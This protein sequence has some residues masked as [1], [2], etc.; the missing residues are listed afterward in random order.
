MKKEGALSSQAPVITGGPRDA[1]EFGEERFDLLPRRFRERWMLQNHLL[2]KCRLVQVH[3][4]P[5]QHVTRVNL[6]ISRNNPGLN[7]GQTSNPGPDFAIQRGWRPGDGAALENCF[8]HEHR[9]KL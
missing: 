9:E 5:E 1:S 6:D 8:G 7:G 4:A 3:N 2:S